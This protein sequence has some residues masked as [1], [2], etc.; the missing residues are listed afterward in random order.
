[1]TL[2]SDC[3]TP[4]APWSIIASA[5]TNSALAGVLAG[6]LLA[7]VAVLYDKDRAEH[8]QTLALFFSGVVTLGIDSYLFSHVTGIKPVAG[9]FDQ[10]CARAW[11]QGIA[12]SGM[13]VVGTIA[14]TAGLVWML[15]RFAIDHPSHSSKFLGLLG[16]VLTGCIILITTLLLVVTAAQYLHVAYRGDLPKGLMN[17]IY[18]LGLIPVFVG[19]AVVF[20]RTRAVV[21]NMPAPG[22][23]PNNSLLPD[24]VVLP[25]ATVGMAILAFFAPVLSGAVPLMPTHWASDPNPLFLGATLIIGVWAPGVI[26][27]LLGCSVPRIP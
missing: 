25:Y 5:S 14:L 15:T 6:F 11:T 13:L 16:G 2:N 3:V 4:E 19:G 20:V 24:P 22:T 10:A 8:A 12:A 26:A 23:A 7:A 27:V 17:T 21:K 18:T 1:M 9:A